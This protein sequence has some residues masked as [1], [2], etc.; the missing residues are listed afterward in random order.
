MTKEDCACLHDLCRDDM[1]QQ[2]VLTGIDTSD[3]NNP[4]YARKLST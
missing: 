2:P 4:G 3:W 1:E